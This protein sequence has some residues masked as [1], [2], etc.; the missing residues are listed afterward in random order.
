M[1]H[2]KRY[3]NRLSLLLPCAFLFFNINGFSQSP[4]GYSGSRHQGNQGGYISSRNKE[5]TLDDVV[6]TE[7]KWMKKRLKLTKEQLEK[8]KEINT[9]YAYSEQDYKSAILQARANALQAADKNEPSHSD[10]S[11]IKKLE[12]KL[13]NLKKQKDDE[14]KAVFTE[15]QFAKYMDKKNELEAELRNS[16]N[17]GQRPPAP[18]GF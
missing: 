3:T 14:L 11:N 1:L 13:D 17:T 16:N 9:R 7:T 15:E 5:T 4:A 12:E 8:V 18:Q 6:N 10:N 2:L